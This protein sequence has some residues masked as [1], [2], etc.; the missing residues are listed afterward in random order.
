MSLFLITFFLIYGGMHALALLRLR[1]ALSLSAGAAAALAVVMVCM[2]IAPV[3]VRVLE[4]QGAEGAA[5]TLAWAGYLWMAFLF[6]FLCSTLLIDL[7]G[8]LVRGANRLS[9]GAYS[10]PLMPPR[11]AIL[12]SLGLAFLISV[13]GYFEAWNIRTERITIETTKL[14]AG[15]DRLTIVQISDV[16]LGLIV[17]CDRMEKI[18]AAVNA[19]KPDIFVS[20]GDL[21]DAQIN[22]LTGLAELLRSVKTRYG[23]YAVTG[24][25]EYYA[26]LDRALQFTREAG[27]TLLRGR[28][29]D[30]GPIT[31]A[32]VD[33]ETG[34]QMGI[35]KPAP[36]SEMLKKLPRH[37]FT[38]LLKH[39]PRFDQASA[40]LFDL[41]LSGHTHRGQIFPFRYVSKIAYP[42]NAGTYELPHGAVLYTNRGTGTWGPPLRFLAP[43]EVTVIE[44]VR[45]ESAFAA[46][47]RR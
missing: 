4:R 6:L 44:L 2:T 47:G 46:D 37:R 24:N 16:H 28:G 15:T 42:Y 5:R 3:L 27:F 22:H 10:V 45:I 14:P 17:R 32:G 23:N 18:I 13:Y 40:G 29:M 19:A 41:Q 20:T 31:I 1:S 43:P 39:R 7:L 9:G 34:A 8:L 11:I 30:I 33:D 21:V 26:G 35:Q 38:L 25:H 36:E 12:V